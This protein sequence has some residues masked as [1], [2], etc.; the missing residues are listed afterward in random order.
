MQTLTTKVY[1]HWRQQ[2]PAKN[3]AVWWNIIRSHSAA[4]H[5]LAAEEMAQFIADG[6][7]HKSFD[8]HD[9]LIVCDQQIQA[10][11]DPHWDTIMSASKRWKYQPHDYKETLWKFWRMAD[12]IIL[13]WDAITKD[14]KQQLFD[15]E[16]A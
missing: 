6:H 9:C 5:S 7:P 8:T 12:E 13:R 16:D 11:A 1:H 10:C 2:E 15:M 3:D 4:E 14:P